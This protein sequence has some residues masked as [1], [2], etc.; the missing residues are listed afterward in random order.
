[1]TDTPTSPP[2]D[3]DKTN[4]ASTT[5]FFLPL[6]KHMQTFPTSDNHSTDPTTDDLDGVTHNQH[7]LIPNYPS[8]TPSLNLNRPTKCK[9]NQISQSNKQ[10]RKN[11]TVL[12]TDPKLTP[13]DN[14]QPIT[15]IKS[16]K[17]ND[18]TTPP[19]SSDTCSSD[20][21]LPTK[22]RSQ[23]FPIFKTAKQARLDGVG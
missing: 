6:S 11:P 16:D 4:D 12:P 21:C 18:T 5:S 15:D 2:T 1:M 14:R 13:T 22:K 9:L 23:L 10:S 19:S 8:S 20:I 7:N 17:L 3:S